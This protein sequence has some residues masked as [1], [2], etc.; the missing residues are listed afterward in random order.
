MDVING[1]FGRSMIITI[2]I[3]DALLVL[4]LAAGAAVSWLRAGDGGEAATGAAPDE[5]ARQFGGPDRPGRFVASLPEPLRTILFQLDLDK[6]GNFASL[7][8]ALHFFAI[9]MLSLITAFNL[10]STRRILRAIWICLASGF[11]VL[12]LD[13]AL[14]FHSAVSPQGA[15]AGAQPLVEF[16][17]RETAFFLLFLLPLAI[18]ASILVFTCSFTFQRHRRSRFLS[19]AAVAAW[20][21][22]LVLDSVGADT[23]L[24]YYRLVSFCE[25]SLEIGGSLLMLAA[26]LGYLRARPGE[27]HVT[28]QE[29]AVR[30]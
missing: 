4:L 16:L 5:A 25:E 12:F 22:S 23:P 8:S 24:R 30:T 9:G 7:F 3:I 27:S 13:E 11:F 15:A 1:R 20:L 6:E 26:L 28:M 18:G 17:G 14:S 29:S 2:L 10:P 19:Y 21:L